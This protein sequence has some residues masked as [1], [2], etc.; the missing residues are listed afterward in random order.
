MIKRINSNKRG[1]TFSFYGDGTKFDIGNNYKYVIDSKNGK[2]YF[3]SSNTKSD[4]K[5]SKKEVKLKKK[6]S[7]GE[8]VVVKK[9]KSLFDLRSEKVVNSI[10]DMDYLQIEIKK[11]IIVVEC[12]K[13]NIETNSSSS[14][15]YVSKGKV[16]DISTKLQICKK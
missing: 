9:L 3:K 7:D 14:N 12:F 8:M 15:R 5:V 13:E 11:D 6:D 4:L 2:I 1:L 16:I 10:K